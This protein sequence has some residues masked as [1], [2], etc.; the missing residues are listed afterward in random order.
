MKITLTSLV[1]LAAFSL[2]TFAQGF[3]YT[4]LEGHTDSISRIVFSPDGRTLASA[5]GDRTIR[6]WDVATG[7]HQHILS[8]H[9]SWIPSITFSHNGLALASADSNGKIRLWNVTT[10]Q[11]RV[12]LEGHNSSVRSVAFSPGW[13]NTRKCKF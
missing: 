2:N 1:L 8:G 11:Y 4:S 9:E 13:E 7:T 3:P 5:S 6:L 12:T 10:G